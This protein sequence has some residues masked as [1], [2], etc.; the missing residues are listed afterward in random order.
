MEQEIVEL[1]ASCSAIIQRTLP[2]KFSDPGSFTMPVAIGDL[3][4]GKTLL[5]LGASINL[6]PLSM[7]KKIE[8][9]K[10]QPI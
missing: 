4:M 7:L 9:I 5:D 8:D 3:T 6:M 1:E 10:L 2:Q